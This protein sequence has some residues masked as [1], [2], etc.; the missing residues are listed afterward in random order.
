M[1]S[2]PLQEEK[3]RAVLPLSSAAQGSASSCRS[4]RTRRKYFSGQN[5][6]TSKQ[7]PQQTFKGEHVQ[8]ITLVII[9]VSMSLEFAASLSRFI[10]AE[11][12]MQTEHCKYCFVTELIY[13]HCIDNRYEIGFKKNT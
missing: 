13:Q 8:G 10:A 2:L 3:W 9:P 12:K 7:K 6:Q 5:K 11:P 4:F 1:L